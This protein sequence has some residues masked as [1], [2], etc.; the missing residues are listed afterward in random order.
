MMIEQTIGAN[1]R[2]RRE[3]AELSLTELARQAKLTKGALSKIERGKG[4]P[5]IAT[6]LRIAGVLKC[7]L[8][9]LFAE[10]ETS[11]PYAFTPCGEG[12]IITRDGTRFGYSYESLALAMSHKTAE[13]FL[14]TIRPGDPQGT[15]H[16]SGQEFIYM[17]SG[18]MEMSIGRQTFHMRRGDSLYFDSSQSH[19][20]R[21]IGKTPAKF[22]CLFIQGAKPTKTS[23]THGRVS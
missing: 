4:S 15:F 12:Q 3:E 10:A 21:I 16:H 19:R 22:L 2:C 8:S 11:L 9:E 18:Q 7:T 6:V 13:P 20:T 5:A 14:L 17:L 23:H 1:I